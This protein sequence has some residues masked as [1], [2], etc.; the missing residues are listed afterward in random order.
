MEKINISFLEKSRKLLKTK[1]PHKNLLLNISKM[2]NPR[3][4]KLLIP[5]LI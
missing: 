2:V 1:D 5:I 4:K 3:L